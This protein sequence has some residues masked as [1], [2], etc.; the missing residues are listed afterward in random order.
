MRNEEIIDTMCGKTRARSTIYL[1]NTFD[2]SRIKQIRPSGWTGKRNDFSVKNNK[3]VQI[4][5]YNHSSITPFYTEKT[6]HT[7]NVSSSY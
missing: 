6:K 3:G 2:N 4:K 7:K 5:S 1:N